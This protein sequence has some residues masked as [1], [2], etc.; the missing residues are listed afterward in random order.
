MSSENGKVLT[1]D[2]VGDAPPEPRAFRRMREAQALTERLER[3]KRE[4]KAGG[5]EASRW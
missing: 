1:T 4:E 3:E 5:P 2:P